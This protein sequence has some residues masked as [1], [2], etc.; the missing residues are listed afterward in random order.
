LIP[1][2]PRRSVGR[3][4]RL[5]SH[6]PILGLAA[7]SVTA[8]SVEVRAVFTMAIRWS[9]IF[10]L[11]SLLVRLGSAT[12]LN[13]NHV[14]DEIHKRSG[15]YDPNSYR[16]LD[17]STSSSPNVG[18]IV[19][20]VIG[21]IAFVALIGW[22]LISRRRKKLTHAE[23]GAKS[24]GLKA[25]SDGWPDLKS[26]FSPDEKHGKLNRLKD[27]LGRRRRPLDSILPTFQ[28]VLPPG[29]VELVNRPA[30]TVPNH[31]PRYPSVLERGSAKKRPTPP[32]LEGYNNFRPTSIADSIRSGDVWGGKTGQQKLQVPPKALVVSTPGRP[33]PG[34]T[35]AGAR[36]AVAQPPKSPSKRRSWFAKHPFKHP[37]IPIRGVDSTLR[38]PPG[39]PMYPGQ[40]QP[41]RHHLEAR[42][43]ARSPRS[44]RL[45]GRHPGNESPR[46]RL[47]PHYEDPGSMKQVRLLEA[48]KSSDTERPRTP[49]QNG[50]RTAVPPQS[51]RPPLRSARF[52][53]EPPTTSYI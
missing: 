41:S 12:I 43:S 7:P 22:Y 39:S 27:V 20:G 16:V 49:T 6:P 5:V 11:Y 37:F 4:F 47:S 34:L 36:S 38:F 26:Q 18:A 28:L 14:R 25:K 46:L 45:G 35:A 42:I 48:L 40:Y 33:L 9:W 31:V 23:E 3:S 53:P 51:A 8:G 50:S 29:S 1:Y 19:G 2:L 15:V 32:P 52:L 13:D 17:N 44:G 24:P 21:G 10:I 30:P